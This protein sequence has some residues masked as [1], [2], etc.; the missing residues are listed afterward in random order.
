LR[1]VTGGL[2]NSNLL[3]TTTISGI[4]FMG[5]QNLGFCTTDLGTIATYPLVAGQKYALVFYG[6]NAPLSL[7]AGPSFQTTYPIGG[8]SSTSLVVDNAAVSGEAIQLFMSGVC[9]D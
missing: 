9:S 7:V 3:G 1:G 6:G 2:P 8:F 4:S 5:D